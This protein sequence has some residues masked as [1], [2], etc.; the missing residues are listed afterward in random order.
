MTATTHHWPRWHA[1]IVAGAYAAPTLTA[2]DAMGHPHS[3]NYPTRH[4]TTALRP[5]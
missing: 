5:F 3:T 2:V 4:A 1:A